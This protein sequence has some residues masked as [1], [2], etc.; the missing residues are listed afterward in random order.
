MVDFHRIFQG[1]TI[2]GIKELSPGYD[3]HASDVWYVKT[4]RREVIV[5]ASGIQ[6]MNDAGAFF[7]SLNILFGVD[8][9]N[10][11]AM[12]TINNTLSGFEA[13]VFP[14]ILDKHKMDREYVVVE[15][16]QGT[17]L[18]S[19]NGL[20]ESELRRFGINL[21]KIHSHR[22]DY[23]GNPIG[24]FKIDLSEVN[25][26]LIRSIS[27]IVDKFYLNEQKIVDYLLEMQR[28]LN[29]LPPPEY[30]S[31]VLPDIDPT[32]FLVDNGAI[33]GLVDTEA[34]VI[35]PRE[36]DFIALEYVLDERSANLISE[37]YKTILPLPDLNP[38]RKVY[39][40]IYRLVEIQS[41]IDI[42]QW[43]LQPALF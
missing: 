43:L 34:Y 8:P 20:S 2:A 42:D 12:D 22:R 32:Q 23:C 37:G 7:N 5:R 40:Y 26:H 10:V 15:L 11:F 38:I 19:F 3:D 27:E 30:S 21:A 1:E 13:F 25:K 39:R 14:R 16:L 33:T 9:T 41:A 24:T 28:I 35:A 17:T 31:F 18:H 36:F 29:E 4:D 6:D